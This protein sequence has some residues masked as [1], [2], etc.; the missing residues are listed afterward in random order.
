M[1]KVAI[2][3]PFAFLILAGILFCHGR[4]QIYQPGVDPFVY[5]WCLNWWP[6][7]V[8]HHL[9]PSISDFI[10]SPTGFPM[11]W[12]NSIP[13]LAVLFAPVTLIFGAIR[14]WNVMA[15]T[16]PAI[17]AYAAFF[18]LRYLTK[19]AYAAFTGALA[20]GFSSYVTAEQLGHI[21]LSLVPFVPLSVLLVLKR[22]NRELE[23]RPFIV[24]MSVLAIMQFGVSTEVLATTAF[25]GLIAFGVLY[26][27][28]ADTHDLKGVAADT[29]IAGLISILVLSPA[30]YYMAIGS[31]QLPKEINPPEM[32]SSDLL[33][34]I[35][36]NPTMFFGSERFAPLSS[37]FTGNFSEQG[38]YL[39]FILVAISI[40]AVI[41]SWG[42]LWAKPLVVMLLVT[43]ICSLGPSLWIAGLNTHIPLPWKIFVHV[44]IIKHALPSRFSLYSTFIV[45][46][47]LTFWLA[48]GGAAKTVRARYAAMVAGLVLLIPNPAFYQFG[49]VETPALFS[50]ETVKAKL[51][52]DANV[53]VLPF[54]YLGNSML[55]QYNSGMSFRMAGG[56]VGFVPQ[57]M[58]KY[59]AIMYFYDAEQAPTQDAFN[60]AVA[61]FCK[62]NHV[63]EIV[64]GPGTSSSLTAAVMAMP[65][66]KVAYGDT[67]I[68]RVPPG[69]V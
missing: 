35:V 41:R 32:F 9:N 67:M 28:Y 48:S 60:E 20:F 13:T 12:A 15:V 65:W 66:Q 5:I 47:F 52:N 16:A 6:Y 19:N 11:W 8:F 24:T 54:G 39:G 4:G 56:Y 63:T 14:A 27:S 17:N 25:F 23:R 43:V 37:K 36:P 1:K 61:V 10:W 18:L 45:S 33:N 40:L 46:I 44:P 26:R 53:V 29:V 21:S 7:A 64:I 3:S 57:S 62:D 22:A 2:A 42:R 58:W 30:L 31:S 51:G 69:G 50:P 68:V 59:K 49:S 55:W 38:A 34:F